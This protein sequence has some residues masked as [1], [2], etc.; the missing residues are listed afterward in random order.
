MKLNGKER[1]AAEFL[2]E[3][4]DNL[5]AGKPT[6]YKKPIVNHL[7]QMGIDLQFISHKKV[8]S[9]VRGK[10]D[11]FPWQITNAPWYIKGCESKTYLP[12]QIKELKQV[13]DHE[14]N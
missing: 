1:E 9:L 2:K 4:A 14:Q 3:F 11:Y 5:L 8:K 12:F 6:S 13:K 10:E 7:K